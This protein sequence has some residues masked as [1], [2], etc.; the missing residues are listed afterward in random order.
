MI[1]IPTLF[2]RGNKE[3]NYHV[4]PMITP[5]CEWVLEGRG[6]MTIKIDGLNAQ[7]KEVT[8]TTGSGDGTQKFKLYKRLKPAD[9]Y[10]EASYIPADRDNPM[11]QYLFEAFDTLNPHQQSLEGIYE[12]Y[13]PKINQ[14]PYKVESHL[15]VKIAPVDGV[16]II[17]NGQTS[18]LRGVGVTAEKLYDAIRTELRSSPE[19]EG[20]VFQFEEPTMTLVAAAKIKRKDFGFVWPPVEVK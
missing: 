10:N 16:L 5:G 12:V 15:M 11:D 20:L 8:D 2:V 1:K 3:N 6:L 18:I 19:I 17:G 14:N 7:V 4:T 9:G 13:G